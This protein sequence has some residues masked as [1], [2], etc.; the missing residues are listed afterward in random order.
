MSA[1]CKACYGTNS[2]CK[3]CEGRGTMRLDAATPASV[4][5][6]IDAAVA[7]L[8]AAIKRLDADMRHLQK[9]LSLPSPMASP[10]PSRTASGVPS[11]GNA[12]RVF[13]ALAAG[14]YDLPRSISGTTPM[15]NRSADR[16]S[17]WQEITSG[18][19]VWHERRF[20]SAARRI[21]AIVAPDAGRRYWEVAL[22]LDDGLFQYGPFAYA[23]DAKRIADTVLRATGYVTP[24]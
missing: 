10:S 3:T 8:V 17:D 9:R 5:A 20:V 11:E 14:A 15:P 1:I 7:P 6:M 2:S 19:F 21:G 16:M 13:S 12:S 24:C 18:A 22:H 4:Q 23:E